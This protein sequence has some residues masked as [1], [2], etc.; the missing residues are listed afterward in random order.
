MFCEN[1]F[2]SLPQLN[3]HVRI[4]HK[5]LINSQIQCN[6]GICTRTYHKFQSLSRHISSEHSNIIQKDCF[7]KNSKD[8]ERKMILK[9]HKFECNLSNMHDSDS[10]HSDNLTE[11]KN[12]SK[13]INQQKFQHN[14]KYVAS[15][16][17]AKLYSENSIDRKTIH[18]I[19]FSMNTF[20]FSICL[21]QLQSEYEELTDL[22]GKIEIM[23][24]S[25]QVF[26]D[27]H[28][29]LKFFKEN[30]FLFMPKKIIITSSLSLRKCKLTTQLLTRIRILL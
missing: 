1:L 4:F 12:E 11:R 3:N 24:N 27:E 16:F 29:T 30:G 25:L 15:K 21:N 9:D 7:R 13:N 23:K 19:I 28:M 10:I 14:V 5:A 22:C 8:S 26:K 17:I 18:D 20:F 6:I 2:S